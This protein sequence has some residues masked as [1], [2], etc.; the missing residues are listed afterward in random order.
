MKIEYDREADAAYLRLSQKKPERSIEVSKYVIIDVDD[1]GQPVGIEVLFASKTLQ[2][3]TPWFSLS[4]AAEYLGFSEV[5]LRR[6]VKAKKIP[7]Y[8]IGRA[9]QFKKE[10][11]DRFIEKHKVSA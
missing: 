9:Y 2:D 6:W 10:D 11:L 7:A 1:N 3:F 4:E 8:K 5:T